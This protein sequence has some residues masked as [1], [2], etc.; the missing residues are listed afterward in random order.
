MTE[1]CRVPL[2]DTARHQSDKGSSHERQTDREAR[3]PTEG[4]ERVMTDKR[5]EKSETEKPGKTRFKVLM[6]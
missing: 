5:E 4:K 6:D 3:E 1:L 2:R